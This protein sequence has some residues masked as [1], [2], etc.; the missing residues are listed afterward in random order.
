M[1]D[2]GPVDLDKLAAE[3]G[4]GTVTTLAPQPADIARL[5][6]AAVREQFE[7]AA[8]AVEG[9]GAELEERRARLEAAAADIDNSLKMVAK[10]AAIIRDKGERVYIEIEQ[11]AEL[12]K[13][14]RAA[15]QEIQSRVARHDDT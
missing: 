12:S 14:I 2:E 10:A 8:Q 13:D 15:C 3:L 11:T 9:L 1:S 7:F 6:A 4:R 5:S